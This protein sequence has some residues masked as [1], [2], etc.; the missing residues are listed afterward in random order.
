MACGILLGLAV[1]T[2]WIAAWYIV[3]FACLFIA[4]EIGA[5]RAAGL[6]SFVRGAFREA[7]WLPLTFI[8]IP[9]AVYVATW[10]NWLFTST[11]Y[12]RN[13]GQLHGVTTPVISALYSLYE[14]HLAGD[15]LRPRAEH[16]APVPV[17]ALGLAAD[18]PAGRV[19]LR[20]LPRAGRRAP[21][22]LPV[23]AGAPA[24]RGR[25]R[26]WPSGPR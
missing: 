20:V 4:W 10:S 13:L 25:R 9:L 6:R 26:S 11:G 19:L 17:A 23:Q 5:R 22:L 24:S 1:G 8:V 21:V 16:P 2:K 3:G 18:H 15:R 7:V 12:D 14:Y